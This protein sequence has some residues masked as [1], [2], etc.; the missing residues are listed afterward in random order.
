MQLAATLFSFLVNS[1]AFLDLGFAVDVHAENENEIYRF[2]LCKKCSINAKRRGVG[3][4][5]SS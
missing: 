5:P 2:Q 1:F 3:K 4:P